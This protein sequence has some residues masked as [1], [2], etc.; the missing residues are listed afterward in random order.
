MKIFLDT[1]DT[2]EIEKY[3]EMG[4]LSGITT[5][6]TFSKRF[7]MHDDIE[8]VK[9]IRASLGCG[10]IHVEALGDTRDEM[11]MNV[12]RL[13][14]Q[15]GDKDL[16][17]KIPFSEEGLLAAKMLI[18]KQ[19]KT[20]LHLIYSIN[21]AILA[22]KVH[23]TYVCPLVGRLDD[24]GHDAMQNV[25]SM[26]QAFDQASETTRI[27]ASSIRHPQ[28][29]SKAYSYGIDAIT[30]PPNVLAQSFYHPLTD[31]GMQTFK[32]DSIVG[33]SISS[34]S[35]KSEL[36]VDVEESIFQCL[37]LMVLHKSG[38]VAIR[39]KTFGLKG[40]FTMGDLKRIIKN[41]VS[42]NTNEKIEQYMQLDPVYIDLN[43]TIADAKSMMQEFDIDQLIVMDN[44][45]VCGI[46]DIQEV[47]F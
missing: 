11:I 31:M 22:A 46:L 16:V 14:T 26:K 9:K 36:V 42:I 5:N 1:L 37:S 17:F 12:E 21:Q 23:S 38:A 32:S 13:V 10:E 19:Y 2:K 40:I 6:P 20:N 47:S 29:I 33:R 34:C 44:N 28:H 25:L 45:M 8:M 41:G 30:I 18:K 27:M 43:E 24:I 39:S 3:S 7:G 4:I 15:T 35:I